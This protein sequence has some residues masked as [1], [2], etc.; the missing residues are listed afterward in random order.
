MTTIAQIITDAYRESNNIAIGQVPTLAEQVEGLSAFNR[1]YKSLLGGRANDGLTTLNIDD[2]NVEITYLDAVK[3]LESSWTPSSGFRFVFNNTSNKTLV[4]NPYP[5]DGE[6]LI[7][8]DVSNNFATYPVTVKGNGRLIEGSTQVVLNTN[9]EITE[10]FYRADT[11]SWVKVSTL[12]VNDIFPFPEEFEDLFSIGI[13]LRLNP[14][15]SS[16]TDNMSLIEF[17]RLKNMFKAR[18]SQVVNI[19]PELALVRLSSTRYV[20]TLDNAIDF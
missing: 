6:R 14:R 11:A 1:F 7:I 13:A 10:Y 15:N 8:Q 9:G 3:T 19:R 18:Y 2:N 20:N 16:I 4:L 5:Q 12:D 17:R